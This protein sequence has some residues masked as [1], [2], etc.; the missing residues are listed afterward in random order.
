MCSVLSKSQ[1][2]SQVSITMHGRAAGSRSINPFT[3]ELLL[4]TMSRLQIFQPDKVALELSGGMNVQVN[5][6]AAAASAK[7][8]QSCP[9]LCD[10]IDDSPPGSS[11]S[12]ILQTRILE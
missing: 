12:G 3:F 9:T 6:A 5:L 4:E 8:L 7:S 11:V 10:P 2:P 1:L